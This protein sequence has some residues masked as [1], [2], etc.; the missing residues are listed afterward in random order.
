MN[1]HFKYLKKNKYNNKILK[2]CEKFSI[3]IKVLN[4]VKNYKSYNQE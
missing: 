4:D 1:K 2:K 3:M